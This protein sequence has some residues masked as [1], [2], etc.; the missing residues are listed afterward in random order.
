MNRTLLLLFAVIILG[1]GAYY[2]STQEKQGP[3]TSVVGADRDF[4]VDREM[5]YKV[6]IA[7]RHGTRTTLERKADHWMF[8]D[9]HIARP[10]AIE[11]LLNTINNIRMRFK[12]T[13]AAVPHMVETLATQGLKVEIYGK[14]DELLK[15][16]YIGGATNDERGTY[17]I[18]EGAEQPYVAE[19]PGWEGNLRYRFNMRGDDWRDKT[20]LKATAEEIAS[21]SVEYPKQQNSSFRLSV[22]NEMSVKPYY[23]LTP[24][25]RAP[26]QEGRVDAFIHNFEALVASSFNNYNEDFDQIVAQVPFAVITV[27]KKD[28]STKSLN[29]F[30]IYP[31]A[32]VDI[33]T[34]TQLDPA[35]VYS[36][37]GQTQDNDLMVVYNE[38]IKKVL[39]SYEFFYQ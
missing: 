29:L 22:E 39:W 16:Y 17:I 5:V 25:I 4:A 11:N 36:Y 23:P 14:E 13:E 15:S 24:V 19:I 27:T 26:L 3:V 21:V 12:P 2:M 35:A 37:H 1:S 7:D 33:K 8:N 18:L 32:N 20:I 31:E 6:F 34:G 38:M 10:D 28:G 30:P 9:E